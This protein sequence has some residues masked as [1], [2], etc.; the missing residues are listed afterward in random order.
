M[1]MEQDWFGWWK[2]LPIG[3]VVRVVQGSSRTTLMRIEDERGTSMAVIMT[4]PGRGTIVHPSQ[5]IVQ[6]V[7]CEVIMKGG[8]NDEGNGTSSGNG[9][10]EA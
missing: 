2:S 9:T 7:D 3:T 8:S 4:L 5:Y 6:G 1:T 10:G